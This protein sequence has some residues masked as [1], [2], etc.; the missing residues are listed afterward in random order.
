MHQ[1]GWIILGFTPV[2]S[3]VTETRSSL[4]ASMDSGTLGHENHNN[5]STHASSNRVLRISAIFRP[6]LFIVYPHLVT[7]SSR[8]SFL[9]MPPTSPFIDS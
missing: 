7:R 5:T 8:T 2:I 3:S 1:C 6:L 9:P 4:G